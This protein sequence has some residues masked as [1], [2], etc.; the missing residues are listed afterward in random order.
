MNKLFSCLSNQKYKKISETHFLNIGN[1]HFEKKQCKNF[2]I[3]ENNLDVLEYQEF[4]FSN[5]GELI[6]IYI[7]CINDKENFFFYNKK[8]LEYNLINVEQFINYINNKKDCPITVIKIIKKIIEFIILRNEKFDEL[9]NKYEPLILSKNIFICLCYDNCKIQEKI[10][11][12]ILKNK[13]E[14]FTITEIVN[15]R[16]LTI[17]LRNQIIKNYLS[18]CKK[19]ELHQNEIYDYVKE[20]LRYFSD[21]QF[22]IACCCYKENNSKFKKIFFK[23]LVLYYYSKNNTISSYEIIKNILTPDDYDELIREHI[24]T[25]FNYKIIENIYK[26]QEELEKKLDMIMKK[27][28]TI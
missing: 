23:K 25:I 26:K 19:L 17:N 10:N 5:F 28:D 8:L 15:Y 22:E 1:L 6:N 4:I 24:P 13:F 14:S 12:E 9:W 3:L 2:E 16:P 7:E 11:N 27:L 20:R 21:E 18:I